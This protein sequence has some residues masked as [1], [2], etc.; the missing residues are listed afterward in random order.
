MRSRRWLLAVAAAGLL[1]CPRLGEPG[2]SGYR[3]PL[4]TLVGFATVPPATGPSLRFDCALDPVLLQLNAVQGKYK[5]L[6]I[7]I[8][9]EGKKPLALSATT[10]RVEVGSAGRMVP[11]FLD[12]AAREPVLW[13]SLLP[14][15]R[16]AL[17][18]PQTVDAGEQESIV[19]FF[20]GLP[21]NA[22]PT[23]LHYTLASLQ[24]TIV[25]QE[26][27]VAVR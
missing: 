21:A 1:L 11:A 26:R 22:V 10:D 14:E 27:A 7:N 17:V 6:R 19:V 2:G 9:N 13:N 3:S 18:Y 12:L 24:Q 23:E 20:T 25:L 4:R 16:R 15:L 5:A 8:H